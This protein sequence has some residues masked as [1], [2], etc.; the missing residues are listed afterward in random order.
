[1]TRSGHWP[2]PERA[3]ELGPKDSLYLNTLGVSLYRTGRYT[4]AVATLELSL[5]AGHGQFDAFDLFFLS[6]AHHRLGH[7]TEALSCKDRAVHWLGGQKN[8][9]AHY[10]KE[11]SAFRVEAEAVLAES[12]GDLPA[13]VFAEE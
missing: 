5:A 4:K 12:P 6:M 3:V 2:W 9:D 13:N 11:L 8:L 10:I 7:H 1:M